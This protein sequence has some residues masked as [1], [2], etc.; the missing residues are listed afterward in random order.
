MIEIVD[1]ADFRAADL[2]DDIEAFG[3]GRQIIADMVDLRIQRLKTEPNTGPLQNIGAGAEG[4]DEGGPLVGTRKLRQIVAG[5]RDQDLGAEALRHGDGLA[6]TVQPGLLV[7]RIRQ[8]DHRLR[9]QAGNRDAGLGNRGGDGIDILVRPTPELDRI[10]PRLMRQPHAIRK[11]VAIARKQP[12]DTSRKL[13]HEILLPHFSQQCAGSAAA[14][15]GSALNM[16]RAP[17]R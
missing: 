6:Q 17:R 7:R 12:L 3:R 11:G 10:E 15:R 5:L 2:I 14:A 8:R 1:D 9:H 16:R 13:P 4:A